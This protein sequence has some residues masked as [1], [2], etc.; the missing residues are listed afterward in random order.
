MFALLLQANTISVTLVSQN[1]HLAQNVIQSAMDIVQKWERLRLGGMS[2]DEMNADV[3]SLIELQFGAISRGPDFQ[4]PNPTPKTTRA[5]A[6]LTL[7]FRRPTEV[8]DLVGISR[9]R[10]GFPIFAN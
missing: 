9:R 8:C 6:I 7:E 3:V 10:R 5:Y 4:T 2:V 1:V